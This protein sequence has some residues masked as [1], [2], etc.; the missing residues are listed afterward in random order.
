MS[1]I[2]HYNAGSGLQAQGSPWSN[3]AGKFKTT[4]DIL[5]NVILFVLYMDVE[6]KKTKISLLA[7]RISNSLRLVYILL[8]SILV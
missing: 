7:V 8:V 2:W 1:M 3:F 6:K 4:Y 5:I